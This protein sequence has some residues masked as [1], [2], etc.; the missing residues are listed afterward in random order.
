MLS[1][2]VTMNDLDILRALLRD[3]VLAPASGTQTNQKDLILTEPQDQSY[4]LRIIRAPYDTI[5]FRAD[6]FPPPRHIFRGSRG[7]R[8]RAD[9]VIVANE[10]ERSWIVYVEMKGGNSALASEIA[11]QLRG[12]HCLVAYCRAIGRQFWGAR[13]FLEPGNYREHF[14]SVK[15]VRSSKKP[16]WPSPRP[17]NDSPETMWKFKNPPRSTLRFRELVEGRHSQA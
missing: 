10:D 8:K 2:G 5:A 17:R 16:S 1:C 3:E 11:A 14:V 9:Y 13:A 12:A 4:E 15:N 6:A 7:E